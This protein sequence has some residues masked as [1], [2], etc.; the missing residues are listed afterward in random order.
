VETELKK[1]KVAMDAGTDT[2]I[3]K[4]KFIKIRKEECRKM[5]QLKKAIFA[6]CVD[7]SMYLNKDHLEK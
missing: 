6:L 5:P 2:V 4:E 3:D 1:L 7:H